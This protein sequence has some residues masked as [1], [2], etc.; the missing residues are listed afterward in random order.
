[1][2]IT[3]KQPRKRRQHADLMAQQAIGDISARLRREMPGKVGEQ[4]AFS[5]RVEITIRDGM[6][7]HVDIVPWDDSRECCLSPAEDI[8]SLIQQ[9][10]HWATR[11]VPRQLVHGHHGFIKVELGIEPDGDGALVSGKPAA[12]YVFKKAYNE[13]LAYDWRHLRESR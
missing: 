5:Y 12:R 4:K 7:Q 9:F 13:R 6:L 8:R 1:M 10:E 2:P 11:F 3:S